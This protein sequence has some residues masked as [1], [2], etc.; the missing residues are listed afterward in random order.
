MGSS[1]R[2]HRKNWDYYNPVNCFV[3]GC[4]D[5]I[6]NTKGVHTMFPNTSSGEGLEQE[7]AETC[8]SL[9]ELSRDKAVHSAWLKAIKL[10]VRLKRFSAGT[11][12]FD[13]QKLPAFDRVRTRAR[14]KQKYGNAALFEAEC[15]KDISRALMS[16]AT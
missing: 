11:D 2:L 13:F 5:E 3:I 9:P 8:L 4:V 15:W 14:V 12:L 6:N 16:F 1:H 7:F 10:L